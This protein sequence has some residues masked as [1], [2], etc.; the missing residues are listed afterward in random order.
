MSNIARTRL[1]GMSALRACIICKTACNEIGD[2]SESCK[3]MESSSWMLEDIENKAT[4][5]RDGECRGCCSLILSEILPTKPM[6]QVTPQEPTTLDPF[7]TRFVRWNQKGA[8]MHQ[9]TESMIEPQVCGTRQSHGVLISIDTCK[10]SCTL[11]YN[12]ITMET[13]QTG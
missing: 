6:I 9:G 12:V 2:S 10:I 5:E 4:G 13:M 11:I 7:S 3:C 1:R 8:K